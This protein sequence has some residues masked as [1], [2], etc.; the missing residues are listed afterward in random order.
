MLDF[1]HFG[2]LHE[3][4]WLSGSATVKDD[5][6]LPCSPRRF[7]GDR[8]GRQTLGGPTLCTESLSAIRGFGG[9]FT[10]LRQPN[11][12]V[13]SHAGQDLC[14]G[15]RQGRHSLHLWELCLNNKAK[16]DSPAP[17]YIWVAWERPDGTE[18]TQSVAVTI[19]PNLQ[20]LC[21]SASGQDNKPGGWVTGSYRVSIQIDDIEV[22]SGSFEVVQKFLKEH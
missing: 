15:F 13:R 16:R 20:Q 22:A 21:L 17:L 7:P 6:P 2:R 1:S 9:E 14:N 19:P 12:Q 3:N 11:R 18:F 4:Q 10:I 8:Q 5:N